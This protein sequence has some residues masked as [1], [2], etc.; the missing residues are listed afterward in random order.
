[1]FAQSKYGFFPS[2]LLKDRG[3]P[4]RGEAHGRDAGAGSRGGGAGAAETRGGDGAATEGHGER[5]FS[6]FLKGNLYG[7]HG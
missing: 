2:W 7:L 5:C 6:A 4:A 3:G 1:M